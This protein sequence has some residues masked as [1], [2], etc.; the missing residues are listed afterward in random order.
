MELELNWEHRRRDL[1]RYKSQTVDVIMH[2]V[3]EEHPDA[4]AFQ[5]LSLNSPHSARHFARTSSSFT[6]LI[7]LHLDFSNIPRNDPSY[8]PNQ[9]CERLT[10]LYLNSVKMDVALQLLALFPDL[11]DYHAT[12]FTKKMNL[13]QPEFAIKAMTQ[14][15]LEWFDWESSVWDNMVFQQLRFSNLKRFTLEVNHRNRNY[16]QSDS[17]S[18]ITSLINFIPASVVHLEVIMKKATPTFS[19]IS[20]LRV[21]GSARYLSSAT[22]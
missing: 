10:S 11:K 21:L 19:T 7:E 1:K 15:N 20:S 3:F 8:I 12:L 9:S 2:L 16:N 22:I 14:E 5:L 4:S 18:S 13:S 17:D 6:H